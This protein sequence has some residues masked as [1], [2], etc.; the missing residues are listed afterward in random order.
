[1]HNVIPLLF[2][3]RKKQQSTR[4]RGLP[5]QSAV[6]PLLCITVVSLQNTA[7]IVP[8]HWTTRLMV[9]ACSS[10]SMFCV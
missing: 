6:R 1:M 9:A 10:V 5:G 8:W 3:H 7:D 4:H 2:V